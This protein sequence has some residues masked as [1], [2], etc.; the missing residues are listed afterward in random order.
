MKNKTI[1]KAIDITLAKIKWEKDQEIPCQLSLWPKIGFEFNIMKW[2]GGGDYFDEFFKILAFYKDGGV[3]IRSSPVG[4][5]RK[6]E[7]IISSLE[8]LVDRFF[9]SVDRELN[10]ITGLH[11]F[12]TEFNLEC[13]S[14]TGRDW[15][16]DHLM[17]D[18][19]QIVQ[20][21]REDGIFK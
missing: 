2:E 8:L 17:E 19:K 6:G 5:P 18:W 3:L 7:G 9:N 15:L 16:V 12:H 13:Q 1:D 14:L 20:R 10:P 4:F 21:K 11:L